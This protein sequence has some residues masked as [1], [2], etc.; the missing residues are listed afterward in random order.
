MMNYFQLRLMK[1]D[2]EEALLENFE[3]ML[4]PSRV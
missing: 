3:K 1:K 2:Y 4:K